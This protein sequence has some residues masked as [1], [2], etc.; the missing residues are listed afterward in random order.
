MQRI[1]ELQPSLIWKY[2]DD[3]LKIPRPSKKEV[4]ILDYIKNFAK[5]KNLLYKQD[6]AGNI[7]IYKKACVGHENRKT[8]VLQSHVDMVCEKNSNINHDFEKDPIPAYIDNGWVRSKGTTLG[9]DNGIGIAAQLAVLSETYIKHGPIECLFTVDEESGLT[10]AFQLE[11]D[12]INGKILLNLDSEDEGELFIG[13][14]GGMDTIAKIPIKMVPV[15]ENSISFKIIITGLKGGH[16]GDDINKG[17]GNANKILSRLLWNATQQFGIR[18]YNFVGGNL[19]NAIPREAYAEVAIKPEDEKDLIDFIERFLNTIRLE[20]LNEPGLKITFESTL[21]PENVL[22][23]KHQNRLLNS[24]HA[25]P[26]GVMEMSQDLSGIVETSSNLASVKFNDKS[27]IEIVTSQRSMIGSAK[28]NISDRIRA[29]FELAQAA[30]IQSDNYPGWTPN[31][32][33]EILKITEKIYKELFNKTPIVRAIH[34]GLECGLFLLKN[35]DLDMISF[36]PTI[37]G[38]HSPDERLEIDSVDKFWKL[39][40]KV[41][42]MIPEN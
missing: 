41:I 33:S 23:R 39:L 38:A 5:E 34:A 24:L 35:P 7:L 9:A 21:L 25:C 4:K 20:L 8:V 29:Q 12:F 40:L 28:K 27:Q 19:K 17:L 14:A 3:I 6:L 15:K 36:G 10:G 18:L 31:K 11:K 30:I 37:K 1:H 2:F 26:N 42:Y 32:E 13:C 16:S 22:K